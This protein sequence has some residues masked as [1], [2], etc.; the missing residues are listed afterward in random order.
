[1]GSRFDVRGRRRLP[2]IRQ[3]TTT[4]CG[5]ACLAMIACWYGAPTDL[6]E[7]RRKYRNSLQ[8]QSL[9]TLVQISRQMGL[10]SRA[11]RCSVSELGK[12]QLPC[13]LHWRFDHFVVLESIG[14]GK[15]TVNDPARGRIDV[16]ATE[17]SQS[18]TGV[19]VE[20]LPG[21]GLRKSVPPVRLRLFDLISSEFWA[22]RQ[23]VGGILLALICECL[24]LVTPFY[25]QTVIDDVVVSGDTMFLDA[26]A[27]AFM[28][29][30]VFQ[31]VATAMRSLTFQRLGFVTTFD[32]ASKV[33]DRLLSLPIA[34]F[35]SRDIGDVQHRFQAI[36]R[37][38]AFVVDS[39]PRLFIDTLFFVL[40]ALLLMMYHPQLAT[41]NLAAV[42]LIAVWRFVVFPYRLRVAGDIATAEAA[43]QTHFLESLRGI[44]SI[45]LMNGA[46]LRSAEWC[47][48]LSDTV[49]ARI[50][51]GNFH[52]LDAG[53][54]QGILNSAR[55]ATVYL[56][57]R[58]ILDE[59]LTVGML[60]AF[61]AY[62]GMLFVR[63]NAIIDAV[64]EYRLLRVPLGRLAEIVFSET[65]AADDG[66]VVLQCGRVELR[67]VVFCY[68]AG[69]APVITGC[70]GII[71]KG[72][73]VAIAG[74]SGSGKST[75][76][77]LIAGCELPSTGQ[78]LH[79]GVS[80]TGC[81]PATLRSQ[82]A[83]VMHDD[84]LVKGSVA[85]NIALF[86]DC[87][88]IDSISA[89]ARL[90]QVHEEIMALPMRYQTRIGETGAA[91]SKGQVQRVLLA[92]AYYR[93]PS[94]LLLDEATSGLDAATEKRVITALQD[95]AITR[96]VVTHSEQMLSAVDEVWWLRDGSLVSSPPAIQHEANN[97]LQ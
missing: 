49:N 36:S 56:F 61:V 31:V 51:A 72:Q 66:A 43:M 77:Q 14:T 12:L 79:D 39:A 95:L 69:D 37:V 53:I 75:L 29:L 28:V 74:A 46:A 10:R 6:V 3:A 92:R 42:A 96:I 27:L 50:R 89:A 62:L 91:L 85:D 16:P 76:L 32:I 86:D 25:L 4:E 97:E 18:F 57:A 1:M 60:A 88:S 22:G 48:R 20:M 59:Q 94:V 26:L 73:F 44:A 41:L 45:K 35:R 81:A 64:F 23:L 80:T 78:V 7:L 52:I 24:V 34:W 11:V 5:L 54:R 65:E 58:Q 2:E 83:C 84:C 15:L 90:A 8:G 9:N 21:A 67:E 40:L 70:D 68:G 30:L 33:L 93:R 55:I 19:A 17:F 47:N 87:G 82:I 13:V 71:D 63:C 38:Q